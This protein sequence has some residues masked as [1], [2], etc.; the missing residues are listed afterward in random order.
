MSEE[1]HARGAVDAR[2]IDELLRDRGEAGEEHDGVEAHV[3]PDR[4]EHD[5]G[6][7][8]AGRDV[9]AEDTAWLDQPT[10]FGLA[11]RDENAV[12]DAVA[13]VEDPAPDERDRDLRGHVR[14]EVDEAEEAA[15]PQ[16]L[17]EEQSQGKPDRHLDRNGPDDVHERQEQ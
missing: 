11:E 3:E 2:R 10:L 6:E 1:R 12:R 15:Q 17:M 14:H 16:P 5:R 9:R 4:H 13:R 8:E 7:R